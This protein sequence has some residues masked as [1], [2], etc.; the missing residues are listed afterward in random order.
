MREFKKVEGQWIVPETTE[1]FGLIIAPG[2]EILPPEGKTLV[3][4]WNG[5]EYGSIPELLGDMERL[6][7][8]EAEKQALTRKFGMYG[9]DV[10]ID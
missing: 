1:L 9:F 8:S 6:E 2:A 7:L 3:F 5:R 10:R 4:T